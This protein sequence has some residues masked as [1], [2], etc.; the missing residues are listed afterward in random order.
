M[1]AVNTP[2]NTWKTVTKALW[3]WTKAQEMLNARKKMRIWV[4]YL[5]ET[6]VK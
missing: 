4:P 5:E 2:N 3:P 6:R 1:V